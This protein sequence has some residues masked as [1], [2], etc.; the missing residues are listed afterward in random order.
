MEFA[1]TITNEAE[2]WCKFGL[3]GDVGSTVKGLSSSASK[4]TTDNTAALTRAQEAYDTCTQVDCNNGF[5][6]QSIFVIPP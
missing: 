6:L 3:T 4:T 2:A 1:S 5:Q